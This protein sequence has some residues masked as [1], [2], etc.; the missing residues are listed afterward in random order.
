MA[1]LLRDSATMN[2]SLSA[3]ECRVAERMATSDVVFLEQFVSLPKMEPATMT[4]AGR[5]VPLPPAFAEVTSLSKVVAMTRRIL[6]AVVLLAFSGSA[7]A[8][9]E[10]RVP[11]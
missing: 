7:F 3:Q 9:D 6:V 10:L 11:S 5:I 4:G 2:L 1:E 8:A